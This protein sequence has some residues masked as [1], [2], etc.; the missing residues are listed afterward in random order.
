MQIF[1]DVNGQLKQSNVTASVSG[2]SCRWALRL[3]AH[4]RSLRRAIITQSR[5][6][7]ANAISR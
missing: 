5:R 2:P 6:L 1:E 3:V 7:I 4:R